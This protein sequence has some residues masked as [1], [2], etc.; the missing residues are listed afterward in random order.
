[1]SQCPSVP[2]R[3]STDTR[4]W[5]RRWDIWDTWDTE[6]V[7]VVWDIALGQV[8]DDGPR[9][10]P[11]QHR[12]LPRRDPRGMGEAMTVL[13]WIGDHGVLVLVLTWII[14][15]FTVSIVGAMQR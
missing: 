9:A 8:Q 1:M 3:S 6:I 4:H 12:P 15:K 13:D 2:R 7:W 10:L 14:G 11:V 5:L